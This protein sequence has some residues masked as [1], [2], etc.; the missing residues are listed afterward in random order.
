MDGRLPKKSESTPVVSNRRRDISCAR[1]RKEYSE[2][3][4]RE[5]MD[6]RG[7]CRPRC[8]RSTMNSLGVLLER[9]NRKPV[10]MVAGVKSSGVGST[11]QTT[12]HPSTDDLGRCDWEWRICKAHHR[13]SLDPESPGDNCE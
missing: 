10:E 1:Y 3:S 13:A 6:T 11:E 12:A 9:E 5:A 2:K 8:L 4:F 7:K